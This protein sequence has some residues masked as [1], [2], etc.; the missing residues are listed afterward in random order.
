MLF[1]V[2]GEMSSPNPSSMHI[3]PGF[4]DFRMI[5]FIVSSG[6]YS[7]ANKLIYVDKLVS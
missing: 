6:F 5:A 4:N 7:H 2:P 3:K 1:N